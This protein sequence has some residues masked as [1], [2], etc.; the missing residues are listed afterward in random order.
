MAA[1]QP[2]KDFA[3]VIIDIG[4]HPDEVARIERKNVFLSQAYRFHFGKA[5]AAKR[6]IP[7]TR[8]VSAILERRLKTGK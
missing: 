8:R 3:T 1:N 2:L 5:K 6:K 4:M 7:L